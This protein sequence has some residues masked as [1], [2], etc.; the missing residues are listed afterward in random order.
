MMTTATRTTHINSHWKR[1]DKRYPIR[2][3][4][5]EFLVCR[6]SNSTYILYICVM[7]RYCVGN[8]NTRQKWFGC[9]W[10]T[11]AFLTVDICNALGLIDVLHEMDLSRERIQRNFHSRTTTELEMIQTK[12]ETQRKKERMK[13]RTKERERERGSE[14]KLRWRCLSYLIFCELRQL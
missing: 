13:D 3:I 10:R 9:G 4:A 2:S 5:I 6:S 12:E 1:A 8:M 11:G 7:F 14:T